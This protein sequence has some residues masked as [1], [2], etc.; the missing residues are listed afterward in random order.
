MIKANELRIENFVNRKYYN[1]QPSNPEWA[2]EH[3]KVVAIKENG[4]ITVKLKGGANSVIDYFEPIPLTDEWLE[5]FG[6]KNGG[7]DF[8]FWYLEDFELSG[9]DFLNAGESIPEYAFNYYL[10]SN[11]HKQIVINYVHTL[12]NLYWSLTGKELTIQF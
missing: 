12:Q 1:P 7:Y 4:S 2:L 11:S 5:K 3:C 10:S 6:F 9:N 8:L